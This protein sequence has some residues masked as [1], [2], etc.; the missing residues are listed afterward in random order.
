MERDGMGWN[1][2]GL[3]GRGA[4]GMDLGRNAAKAHLP[5]SKPKGLGLGRGAI[6]EDGAGRDGMGL[7]GAGRGGTGWGGKWVG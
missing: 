6:G 4:D 1:G 5:F 2:T 3:G 7:D